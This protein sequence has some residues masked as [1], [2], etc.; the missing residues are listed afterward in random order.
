MADWARR[1]LT[2]T[3]AAWLA[4][5]TGSA[6][7]QPANAKYTGWGTEALSCG[8]SGAG[9]DTAA[10]VPVRGL[11]PGFRTLHLAH[12]GSEIHHRIGTYVDAATHQLFAG[13]VVT[14]PDGRERFALHN[15]HTGSP[16]PLPQP[17]GGGVFPGPAR[18]DLGRNTLGVERR[19]GLKADLRKIDMP[20]WILLEGVVETAGRRHRVEYGRIGTLRKDQD[21]SHYICRSVE[22]GPAEEFFLAIV[23]GQ[24]GRVVRDA[25]A[26]VRD[27]GA[28]ALLALPARQVSHLMTGEERLL[29]FIHDH[30][31][32]VVDAGLDGREIRVR[33]GVVLVAKSVIDGIARAHG[34]SGHYNTLSD[35]EMSWHVLERA[36]RTGSPLRTASPPRTALRKDTFGGSGLSIGA[37]QTDFGQHMD[38]ARVLV[39][40]MQA[41]GHLPPGE[42]ALHEAF[43]ML[44]TKDDPGVLFRDGMG[45]HLNLFANTPDGRDMIDDWDERNR[46]EAAD[47]VAMHVVATFPLQGRGVLDSNHPDNADAW[48]L[49]GAVA[50]IRPGGPYTWL[51]AFQAIRDMPDPT[52]A[53]IVRELK[54]VK[55]F[56]EVSG[57]RILRALGIADPDAR[58]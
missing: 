18:Q 29:T 15:L 41:S 17:D 20:S 54:K 22:G 35:A 43:W 53:G 13:Y 12:E 44:T 58:P 30:P 2:G 31:I 14:L 33:G 11:E 1:I 3:T 34:R 27:K 57:P 50:S 8:D 7:A 5:A 48:R 19:I 42:N 32:V 6:G 52:L 23:H 36:C 39:R 21:W 55:G 4:L 9:I 10:P 45:I 25:C 56:A 49:L 46:R 37:T 40:A 38:R 51:D 26:A 16:V 28:A 24:D 47:R